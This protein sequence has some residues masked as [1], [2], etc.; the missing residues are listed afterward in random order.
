MELKAAVTEVREETEPTAMGGSVAQG[1]TCTYPSREDVAMIYA[2]YADELW[3]SMAGSGARI[4]IRQMMNPLLT[5]YHNTY[6]V[7]AYR[8]E[9]TR[10]AHQMHKYASENAGRRPCGATDRGQHETFVKVVS[11]ALPRA[12]NW[13]TTEELTQ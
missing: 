8:Q 2:E 1:G 10:G 12:P 5:L 11:R 13:Y 7:K 6:G 4:P 3:A 9:L